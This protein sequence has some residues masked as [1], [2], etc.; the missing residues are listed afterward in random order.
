M[1]FLITSGIFLLL[2]GQLWGQ[3]GI[4]H[5]RCKSADNSWLELSETGAELYDAL[6]DELYKGKIELVRQSPLQYRFS[7][8]GGRYFLTLDK[9]KSRLFHVYE[10]SSAI[11][12]R[13]YCPK[14]SLPK[15]IWAPILGLWESADESLLNVELSGFAV[16]M[17]NL[18]EK[19][20]EGALAVEELSK[21]SVKYRLKDYHIFTDFNT[22]DKIWVY[23]HGLNRLFTRQN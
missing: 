19:T 14:T 20:L 17:D 6:F 2:A 13:F 16:I 4:I 18:T 15:D 1:R 23:R 12:R 9:Y 11:T 10:S 22:P 7:V 3:E 8:P 5:Q 21:T